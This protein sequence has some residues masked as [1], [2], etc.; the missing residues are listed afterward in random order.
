MLHAENADLYPS[1][2]I[3]MSSIFEGLNTDVNTGLKIEARHFTWLLNHKETRSMLKTLKFT[4]SR[5]KVDENIIKL[6]KKSLEENYS[7]EGVKLLIEGVAAPLIEN[8]GKKIRF[9][10]QPFSQCG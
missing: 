6:C 4:K 3:L 1:V 9:Y 8:A 5:K 7:A 2:K 10:R